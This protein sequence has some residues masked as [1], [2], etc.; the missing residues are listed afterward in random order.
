M[1]PQRYIVTGIGT[2]VGKTVVSAILTEKLQA[3]YW[4]PIQAGLPKDADTVQ[5]LISNN[6]SVI[7]PE[8][9]VLQTPASPHDAARQDGVTI[10]LPDL[11]LPETRNHLIIEGAG[12]IMVPLNEKIT[13]LDVFKQWQLPVILVSRHYLG[14]INHTL[15]SIQ[16]LQSENIPLKGIVFVGDENPATENVILEMTQV[17]YLGRI[18]YFE[19]LNKEEIRES[20]EKI[21]L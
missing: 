10:T 14:S 16:V 8:K 9:F 19:S 6:R 5:S 17:K 4:K 21:K 1:N 13:F 2:D 15:M 20:I 3:D 12:G 18:D 7:H 11:S